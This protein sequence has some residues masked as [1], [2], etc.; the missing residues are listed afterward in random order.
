VKKQ[1]IMEWE[2][3]LLKKFL[4]FGLFFCIFAMPVLFA[5]TVS[6]LVIETGPLPEGPRSQYSKLWENNLMD[7]FFDNGHIVS[8]G[9][10]VRLNH[11]S[12]DSFPIEAMNDF[13][14]AKKSGMDYFLVAIIEHPDRDATW[15][16]EIVY[17]RLFSTKTQDLINEQVYEDNQPRSAKEENDN[18]KMTIGL[19]AAKI[20]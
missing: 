4:I 9:R 19:M 14:E 7:V 18:I 15:K 2:T 1:P 3:F 6:C 10:M 5:A 17:L 12:K 20:K 8:N 13:E 16:S 11:R